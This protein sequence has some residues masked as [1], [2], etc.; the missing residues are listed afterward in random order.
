MN[1]LKTSMKTMTCKQMGGA[2]EEKFQAATFEEMVR[3]SQEHGRKMAEQDDQPHLEAMLAIGE[4]MNDPIAMQEWENSVRKV[5]DE[6]PE[7]N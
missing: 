4:K 6:L 5:F 3:L 1:N 7:D 2:C